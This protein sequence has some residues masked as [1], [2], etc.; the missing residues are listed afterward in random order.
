MVAGLLLAFAA[1]SP[2]P[3]LAEE[4]PMLDGPKASVHEQ[5]LRIPGDPLRPVELEVT[6]LM[7][8]GAGPFPLAV[9]N[10]G[11]DG[12]VRPALAPRYRTTFSAYYFLSRGYA[13][14]LPMMRG[15]AGSGGQVSAAG[16]DFARVGRE[17]AADIAAVIDYASRLPMVDASRVVVAGQSFGGWNSLAYGAVAAPNVKGLIEFAGGIMTSDCNDPGQGMAAGV[18]EFG[19]FTRIPSIWFHGDNDHLFPPEIW[20]RNYQRY[21]A[22]GGQAELVAYGSFGEDAHNFLGS[23]AALKIW[24]PRVDD[25]LARIGMPHQILYP[26]YLPVEPPAPTHFA[27]ITDTAA[28]PFMKDAGKALYEQFL[29][30]PLPRAFVIAPGFASS[31]SGGFD[32]ITRSLE[33]CRTRSSECGVYAYDND[34]VWTE[35]PSQAQRIYNVTVAA[36]RTTTLNSSFA[37]NP[38]CTPRGLPR[39]W[40]T[41][42]PAHGTAKSLAREDFPRFA[43]NSP[44]ARCA[45]SKVPVAVIDYTPDTGFVG[46]DYLVFE[47]DTLDHQ[48]K[49]FRISIVVK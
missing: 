36:D 49:V 13:V 2:L 45:Q 7:P 24:T 18:A 27:D 40:V 44:L 41:Q 16:C 11:A 21:T 47:E 28:V 25:F 4:E 6:L 48:N 33:A 12:K 19:S 30:K 1:I 46:T 38:D 43:P 39:L 9:M 26:A 20:R 37:V 5:V 10:H 35:P 8:G 31:Q 3:A 32:P 29:Q 15:Y 17:N 23:G 22:A 42:Q 14:M 34:V